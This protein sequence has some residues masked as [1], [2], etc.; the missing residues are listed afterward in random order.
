MSTFRDF[1][2]RLRGEGRVAV[3]KEPVS[4]DLDLAG[5]MH[6]LDGKPVL[7]P[8]VEGSAFAAVGNVFSTR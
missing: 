1:I 5:I 7:A 8:Q 4:R 3:L 6:G 2:E